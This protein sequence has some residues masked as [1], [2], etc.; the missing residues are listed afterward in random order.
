[1]S[2]IYKHSL[3][4]FSFDYGIV[5]V[6]Y[7]DVLTVGIQNGILYAWIQQEINEVSRMRLLIL[8]TGQE[9]DDRESGNYI[10]SAISDYYVW[11]VFKQY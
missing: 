7:G 11:H 8:P 2:V 4:A 9:F 5:D 3:Q 1:M 10:G 6:P